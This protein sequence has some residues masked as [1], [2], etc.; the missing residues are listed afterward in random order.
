MGV[1]TADE[2]EPFIRLGLD[3]R[4]DLTASL[5]RGWLTWTHRQVGRPEVFEHEALRT[6]ENITLTTAGQY[7][8]TTGV[9]AV[10]GVRNSTQGYRLDA[11]DQTWID[12]RTTT[13]GQPGYYHSSGELVLL[14]TTQPIRT[15][16]IYP[17]PS[18]EFV[19][20]T[21]A[22]REIMQASSFSAGSQRSD[23]EDPW[24]EVLIQGAIWRA[25]RT[26]GNTIRADRAL[27]DFVALINE[28]QETA[29]TEA[30]HDRRR[31]WDISR[32]G[33]QW[34]QPS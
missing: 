11:V 5:Y 10:R 12:D 2:M 28:I 8:L 22:V 4:T 25:W 19:G 26:L 20:D 16:Q 13:T 27:E 3:N 23:L 15:L 29:N 6:S 7:T 21:L 31:G 1:L 30:L 32:E 24:D 17:T 34:Q 18:T 14:A 9:I 33:R